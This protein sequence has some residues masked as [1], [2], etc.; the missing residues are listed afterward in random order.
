M[1]VLLTEWYMSQDYYIVSPKSIQ[2]PWCFVI[3]STD[4]DSMI[5]EET[6]AFDKWAQEFTHLFE[7][8]D[9]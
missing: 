4:D 2:A 9:I 1:W 5:H 8:S 6:L 7:Q 3:E